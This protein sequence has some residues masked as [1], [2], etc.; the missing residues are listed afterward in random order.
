M[1][2]VEM[3][4]S[5]SNK[6]DC[7][8]EDGNKMRP[9]PA[10]KLFDRYMQNPEPLYNIAVKF[11][12]NFFEKEVSEKDVKEHCE[13]KQKIEQSLLPPEEKK[14][15]LEYLELGVKGLKDKNY[16][17]CG[18]LVRRSVH[19]ACLYLEKNRATLKIQEPALWFGLEAK[20]MKAWC[21]NGM[22]AMAKEEKRAI[23]SGAAPFAE[24]PKDERKIL[25]K[26]I[27]SALKK[28]DEIAVFLTLEA[29]YEFYHL[30]QGSQEKRL[31]VMAA[32]MNT[33]LAP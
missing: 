3:F 27:D 28:N 2:I 21:E 5:R 10:R 4:S 23:T 11:S 29:I 9:L 14:M 26:V 1:K 8:T 18:S 30:G 20:I 13:T 12:Y 25:K 22:R 33:L 24:I 7:Q 31:G 32:I 15:L 16:C 19:V 6:A 17:S